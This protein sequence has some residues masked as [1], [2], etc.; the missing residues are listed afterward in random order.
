MLQAIPKR[1]TDVPLKSILVPTDY[2]PASDKALRNALTIAKHYGATLHLVHVVS[3][4]GLNRVGADATAQAT[5]PAAEEAGALERQLAATGALDGIVHDVI[6]S[7][8]DM[9]NVQ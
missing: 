4:L 5:V 1:S 7:N 3:S 2:S 9:R 6:V 8:G